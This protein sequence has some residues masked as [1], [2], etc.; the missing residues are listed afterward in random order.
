MYSHHLNRFINKVC[1]LILNERDACMM[2]N[3]LYLLKSNRYVVRAFN[4]QLP[5]NIDIFYL[6]IGGDTG[7]SQICFHN[8]PSMLSL[9][10]GSAILEVGNE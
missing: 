10:I 4:T 6:D 1:F 5:I 2:N 3:A 9:L 7:T 8:T